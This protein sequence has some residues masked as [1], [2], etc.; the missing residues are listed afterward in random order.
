MNGGFPFG[1]F[2]LK[3]VHI[4]NFQKYGVLVGNMSF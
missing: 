1:G 3:V 4:F 2:M